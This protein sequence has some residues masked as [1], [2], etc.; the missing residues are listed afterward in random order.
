MQAL[1]VGCEVRTKKKTLGL[2]FFKG[3]LLLMALKI[4]L[5]DKVHTPTFTYLFHLN[6]FIGALF[7]ELNVY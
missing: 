7:T 4:D 1:E 3:S 6:S 2:S 5:W